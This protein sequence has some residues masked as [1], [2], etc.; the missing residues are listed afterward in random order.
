M[1]IFTLR[2]GQNHIVGTIS[3]NSNGDSVAGNR[4]DSILGRSSQDF[5][6]TRDGSDRLVSNNIADASLLFRK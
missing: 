6:N 1:K 3:T 4:R 5:N 2:D